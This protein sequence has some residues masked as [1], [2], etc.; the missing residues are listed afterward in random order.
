MYIY[1][2]CCCLASKSEHIVEMLARTLLTVVCWC[3]REVLGELDQ[4]QQQQLTIEFYMATLNNLD[5]QLVVLTNV[6]NAPRLFV[7][8]LAEIRRRS[9]Y[10]TQFKKATYIS[11]TSIYIEKTN[12]AL[13]FH[14]IFVWFLLGIIVSILCIN[15]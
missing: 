13:L 4:M 2:I 14:E 3:D 1:M 6:V 10:S 5:D 7:R 8:A 9:S 11:R 12:F 15:L